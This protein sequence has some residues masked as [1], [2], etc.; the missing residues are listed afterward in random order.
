[1]RT[2]LSLAVLC[3][4]S[5][6]Q[7]Q[8]AELARI[9]SGSG[10][11]SRLSKLGE[12]LGG[13]QIDLITVAAE[14]PVP[15]N[16]RPAILCVA[17]LDGTRKLGP[18][19]AIEHL[20]HL[21]D[22]HRN[23]D[24]TTRQLLADK[25]VFIVPMLSPDAFALQRSGN[26]RA[27]DLDRDG[28]TDE[29]APRDLDGDGRVCQMRWRDVDG[30]WVID[31][32]DPRLMRKA[33]RK[34]GERGTH[35]LA[36][37]CA[38]ADG[39]GSRGE[40]DGQG[41]AIFRNFAQRHTEFDR[42]AGLFPMSEPE[43]RALADFVFAHRNI[44]MAFVWDGDDNLLATPKSDSAKPRIQRDGVHEDDVPLFERIGAL[45]RQRTS[46]SGASSPRMDGSLWAWLYLQA[47]IPT[48]ASDVWRVPRGGKEGE[49]VTTDDQARIAQ[50]DKLKTGFAPWHAFRHP[51]LGEVEVGGFVQGHD[52]ELCS[53][54]ER[55][56]I[57]AAHHGFL[58]EVAAMCSRTS[59]RSFTRKALGDGV[60]RLEATVVNDGSWPTL[61]AMAEET[62]RFGRPR[63]QLVGDGVEL[64]AGER[65]VEL[66]TLDAAGGKVEASWIV[67]GKA[68]ATVGVELVVDPIGK[69]RKEVTL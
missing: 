36:P 22:D 9:C 53:S 19:L 39:D 7:D 21:V 63:I 27:L 44:V 65:R 49:V 52:D 54:D 56:T 8:G 31:D 61:C 13:R 14:G 38:D 35:S 33:D 15:E 10:G 47:G 11:V 20:R 25:V 5:A 32:R 41:V 57:F 30:E 2:L 18:A 3:A 6:A 46:R 45:Y 43:T 26:A 48:F 16:E 66:R 28:R 64:L 55:S 51:E 34:K 68:G 60:F 40:D 69:D 4:A 58:L 17:G 23:G 29:D 12:S 37:E 50:C 62:R 59:I 1:M 42:R 24:A 67:S